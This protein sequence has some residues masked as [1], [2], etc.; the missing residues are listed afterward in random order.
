[1]ALFTSPEESAENP[2]STWK[3]VKVATGV[4]HLT[5]KDGG[6][7]ESF[8]T[9]ANAEAAT[10]TGFMFFAY[11]KEAAWF[12]GAAIPNWKPYAECLAAR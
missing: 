3:V 8:K 1:M 11:E 5:T 4:W 7:L 10:E 6:V 2:P 12:N 9:K